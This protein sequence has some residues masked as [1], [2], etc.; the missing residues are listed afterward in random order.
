M[1]L[2]ISRINVGFGGKVYQL[3]DGDL[4]LFDVSE[5]VGRENDKWH[6]VTDSDELPLL[7]YRYYSD[8][9][10]DAQDYWFAIARANPDIFNPLDLS[11]VRGK[12]ILIPYLFNVIA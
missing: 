6:R 8:L 2:K 4:F 5:Y 7:A 12:L 1:A 10:K 9:V 11:E 3:E